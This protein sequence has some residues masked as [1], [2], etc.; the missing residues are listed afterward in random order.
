MR[1]VW[2]DPVVA[3]GPGTGEETAR[4][5]F[6]SGSTQQSSRSSNGRIR[7]T[8]IASYHKSIH[9]VRKTSY[10]PFRLFARSEVLGMQN[11]F[12]GA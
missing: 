4:I 11:S 9:I 8:R 10:R 12:L 7:Q 2:P 6:L 3:N 5:L 1:S